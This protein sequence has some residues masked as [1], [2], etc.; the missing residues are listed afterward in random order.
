MAHSS[1]P[2]TK[3]PGKTEFAGRRRAPTRRAG[4]NSHP[5]TTGGEFQRV[6]MP[7]YRLAPGGS[8]KVTMLLPA[9]GGTFVGFGGWFAFSD[10][11]SIEVIGLDGR[12]YVDA[13]S[14]WPNWSKIGGMWPASER[15]T[16]VTI[17]F[18]APEDGSGGDISIY[19]FASGIITHDYLVDARDALL[20]NMWTF[21]PEANFYNPRLEPD[22]DL[23]GAIEALAADIIL[24]SCNRCARYLPINTDD[25]RQQ[26]SFSNH[27]VAEHRTPCKHATFGRLT[28]S[29][30]GEVLKLHHGYQ[31]ECRF[32]KKFEVNAAHNPQRS[33]AQMKEDGARRRHFEL[34]LTEL[35]GGSPQLRFRA[36]NG[37]AELAPSIW[38]KF[39][40]RCFNCEIPITSAREMN[41]DHTRPLAL[42]W[43][44]DGSATCLCKTCNSEKRDRSPVEF[45]GDGPKLEALSLATGISLEELRNPTPN[46]EALRIL[47]GR[48]PWLFSDF[49]T[50]PDLIKIRDGKRT[51][52]LVLKALEKVLARAAPSERFALAPPPGG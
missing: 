26:L 30:T 9:G 19:E 33:A 46:L 45:Y 16:Y 41:L 5:D 1:L 52:E 13:R 25:E 23:S 4:F 50:R 44:L 21:S 20:R 11:I 40:R 35:Y 17:T 3:L 18:S 48:L 32:C 36:S 38:E 39:G 34:L 2:S 7:V 28:D 14:A 43:P 10:G 49:L 12:R 24:K 51:S 8:A 27:C 22:I 31:L 47:R 29:A 37:G 6:T 42:L 15:E